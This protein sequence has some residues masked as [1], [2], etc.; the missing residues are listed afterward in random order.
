MVVRVTQDHINNALPFNSVKWAIALALQDA[1][2]KEGTFVERSSIV[3]THPDHDW[4]AKLFFCS[5][6]I[7]EW[8]NDAIKGYRTKP[9]DIE[10]DEEILIVKRYEY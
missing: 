1:G 5:D 4:D 3:V 7:K 6:E 8:Q 9:I 2:A 10:F